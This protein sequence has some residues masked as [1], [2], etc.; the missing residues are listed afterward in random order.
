MVG[1]IT[2]S[3][4]S[5]GLS[6]KLDKPEG[7]GCA[8]PGLYAHRRAEFQVRAYEIDIEVC[9]GLEVI[10]PKQSVISRHDASERK[11]SVGPAERSAIAIRAEPGITCGNERDEGTGGR[12]VVAVEDH[13]G[14][15]AA[16][17][18]YL[19]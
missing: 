15:A 9:V 6:V 18:A 16:I 12:H 5:A 10:P 17:G 8:L 13:A 7:N 14:N 3:C 1:M 4:P 11:A 19:N 2:R